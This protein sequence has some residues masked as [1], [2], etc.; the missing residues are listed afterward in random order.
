MATSA[1]YIS[2][3]GMMAPL[4]QSEVL[5]RRH[6]LENQKIRYSNGAK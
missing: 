2:Y 5:T 3:D 6:G 1:L 4:G